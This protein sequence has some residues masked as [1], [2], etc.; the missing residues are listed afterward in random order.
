[1]LKK[2]LVIENEKGEKFYHEEDVRA[3]IEIL[4]AEL[5]ELRLAM[6]QAQAKSKLYAEKR[7]M[8]CGD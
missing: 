8:L 3:L 5:F 1:M 4:E 6:S 2:A 7:K